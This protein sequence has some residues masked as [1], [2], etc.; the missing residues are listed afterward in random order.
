[1]AR[2]HYDILQIK[3]DA[4]AD[5]IQRAYRKLAMRYHP[6]RNSAPDAAVQMAAINEA[7]EVLQDPLQRGNVE[8]PAAVVHH[9]AQVFHHPIALSRHF[10]GRKG[11]LWLDQGSAHRVD[12]DEG[13]TSP[14]CD[15]RR[16]SGSGL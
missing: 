9:L 12:R 10:L 13:R 2:K 14:G 7:Y 8:Q 1:M 11:D 3:P 16:R 15:C 5:E 6:D 4:S